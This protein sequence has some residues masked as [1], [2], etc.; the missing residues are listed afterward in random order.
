MEKILQGR[1]VCIFLLLYSLFGTDAVRT[2]EPEKNLQGAEEILKK[3]KSTHKKKLIAKE[4]TPSIVPKRNLRS[5]STI[6][7]TLETKPISKAAPRTAN[8]LKQTKKP[9]TSTKN[10]TTKSPPTP[11]QKESLKRQ[12]PLDE[13]KPEVKKSK[14]NPTAV[15]NVPKTRNLRSKV[16]YLLFFISLPH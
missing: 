10:A 15:A 11:P 1:R 4:K 12:H 2:W 7:T 8:Q 6:D 5:N 16:F 13:D 3:W 9:A 14:L